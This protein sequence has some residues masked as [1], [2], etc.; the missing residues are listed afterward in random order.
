[1]ARFNHGERYRLLSLML[2]SSVV[3]RHSATAR[4][5]FR[6]RTQSATLPVSASLSAM[7]QSRFCEAWTASLDPARLSQEPC[8]GG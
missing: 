1:M 8:L 3:K 4:L 6:S 7:R 2:E 5:L